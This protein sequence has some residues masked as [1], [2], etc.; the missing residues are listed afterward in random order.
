MKETKT[1]M[2]AKTKKILLWSG[3]GLA[4]IG[5]ICIG[6]KKFSKKSLDQ[7]MGDEDK[8]VK[9]SSDATGGGKVCWEHTGKGSH[10]VPCETKSNM[11]EKG[12]NYGTNNLNL[13]K[14]NVNTPIHSFK[15]N[16]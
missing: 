10:Q 3:F 2:E 14:A 4:L 12:E 9:K 13:S 5:G 16:T 11:G 7:K 15:K 6:V 1:N 8:P